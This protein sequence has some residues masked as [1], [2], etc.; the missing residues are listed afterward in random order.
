LLRMTL[1]G[2]VG[3]RNTS[4][5]TRHYMVAV[6]CVEEGTR[7]KATPLHTLRR[8]TGRGTKV[9]RAPYIE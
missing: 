6:W 5:K 1:A 4:L 7:A 8:K 9:G 3:V 2:F